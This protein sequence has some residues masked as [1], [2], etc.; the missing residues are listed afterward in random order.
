LKQESAS[1][2]GGS[3]PPRSDR[4]QAL[5][6]AA[7]RRIASEGFEGLRTRDVAADVGV[8]IATLHYYFPTKEALIRGVIGHAMQRFMATMPDEGTPLAQLR[9]H[10]AELA[11]LLKTDQ[12]LWAVLGELVL[13]APRD[14]ELE[15]IFRQIDEYWH[16]KLR[17]LLSACMEQGTVDRSLDPDG[18][19]A[20]MIAA[21]RGVALPTATGFQPDQID[22]V[23]LQFDRLLG[24]SA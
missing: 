8:N 6:A 1:I 17:E 18:V 2:G 9:A 23:F 10:L 7:F 19:T 21:L 3:E 11:Q 24:L 14:A 16:R 5:V 20:L 12:Q 4:R 22:K 15:A 13:R